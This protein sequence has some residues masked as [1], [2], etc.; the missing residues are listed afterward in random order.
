ML[1]FQNE[2]AIRSLDEQQRLDWQRGYQVVDPA[3]GS[4]LVTPG[5]NA[6]ELDVAAG[7]VNVGGTTVSATQQTLDLSADV[8]ATPKAAVVYRD[9]NGDAQ[10]QTGP[11][12]AR[13]PSGQDVRNT[14]LPIPPTLFNVNGTVLAEVLLDDS[15]GD[16]TSSELRDRRI[17]AELKLNSLSTEEAQIT[18][19]TE[20]RAHLDSDFNITSGVWETIPLSEDKDTRAEFASNQFVPDETR[21]YRVEL[22][23]GFGIAA[24]GDDIGVGFWNATQSDLLIRGQESAGSANPI[25]ASNSKTLELSAG[26]AYELQARNLSGDDSITATNSDTFLVIKAD[27]VDG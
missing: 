14:F 27:A 10:Y 18:N 5:G 9:T 7:D 15:V 26:D 13:D 23:A 6:Y 24:D 22:S 21:D 25:T 3:G 16:V 20:V 17:P 19:L 2:D 8:E 12:A 11:T 1:D 4:N